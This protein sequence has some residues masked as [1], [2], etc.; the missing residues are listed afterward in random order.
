M[1]FTYD[2]SSAVDATLAISKVRLEIGD[3]VS[4]M[5]VRPDGSNLS[6]EEI[7]N[8][9]DE[10]DYNIMRT[11]ARACEALSRMWSSIATITVGPRKEEL[12]KVST[13]W[14]KQAKAIRDIYGGTS[15]SA[16]SVGTSRE[17]GYSI[18]AEE[19]E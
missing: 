3:T 18:A 13:E 19:T 16:F 7:S 9:L 14:A 1:T 2:L 11:A 8:W 6:D 12:G 4:A 15:S 10:E 17:D 5:G